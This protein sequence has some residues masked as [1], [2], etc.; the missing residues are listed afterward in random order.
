[1]RLKNQNLGSLY[2]IKDIPPSTNCQNCK[3][4]TRLRML[5]MGLLP[6]SIIELLEHSNGLWVLNVLN[7]KGTKEFSIALRD[8]EAERIVLE[9]NECFLRFESLR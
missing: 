7:E 6:G 2:K 5:E 4:C 8:D 1:M 3:V 9:E